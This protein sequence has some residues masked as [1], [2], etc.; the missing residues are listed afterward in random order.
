MSGLPS[1]IPLGLFAI[2]NTK[3]ENTELSWSYVDSEDIEYFEIQ[4]YNEEQRKWLPYDG[5][6]GIIKKK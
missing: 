1:N 6:N 4:Y 3:T 2:Y 5:R